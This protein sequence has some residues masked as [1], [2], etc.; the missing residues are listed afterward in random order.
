M[1]THQMNQSMSQMSGDTSLASSTAPM[2]V[3]IEYARKYY[4]E[5]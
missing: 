3:D 1:I 4:T 5:I 2:H